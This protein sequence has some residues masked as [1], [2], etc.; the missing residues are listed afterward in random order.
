MKIL[1][2]I[3]AANMKPKWQLKKKRTSKKNTLINKYML[4]KYVY[5]PLWICFLR[6]IHILI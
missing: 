5:Y 6:T 3:I 4:A 1:I 2:S